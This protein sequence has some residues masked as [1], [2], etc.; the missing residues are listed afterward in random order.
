M[1]GYL[2]S[3]RD[4]YMFAGLIL[5]II[6]V[7]GFFA[8]FLTSNRELARI[9]SQY[10]EMSLLNE[11]FISLKAKVDEAERKKKLSKINGVIPA[12]DEVFS[13]LGLKN[14]IKSI[15]PAG[16]RE[17]SGSIEEEADVSVEKVSMNEMVNLFYKI[18]NSPMLLVIKKA[19]IKTSFEKPDL[20]NL[21]LTV[22]FIHE[23]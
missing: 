3:K 1:R 6:T 13:P 10:A 19:G 12:L 5:L 8:Y 18:E 17:I 9:K 22:S 21:N 11:E 23:K 7:I 4:A 16:S 15:K 14:R 2:S 20:L